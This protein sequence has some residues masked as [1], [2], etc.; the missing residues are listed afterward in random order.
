MTEAGLEVLL[1]RGAWRLRAER[2][3]WAGL[4]AFG[5]GVV[6]A[7]VLI[8][9][10][11]LFPVGPGAMP[12][13]GTV[14]VQ[15]ALVLPLLM[16]A[17]TLALVYARPNPLL[18]TVALRMDVRAGTAEHLVTWYQLRVAAPFPLPLREGVGGGDRL[19]EAAGGGDLELQ[20]G[21]RQAQA[22]ATLALAARFDPKRLLPIRLPEWSRAL[23]LAL[24][25]LCCALLMPPRA[26]TARGL[27]ANELSGLAGLRDGGGLNGAA[28]GD[29]HA[30]HVQV[31][32]PTELL[33]FQLKA[34]DPLLPAA[35]KAEA[36]KELLKKIGSV[37]ESEL[38]PEVRELLNS[39]RS[40]VAIKNGADKTGTQEGAQESAG[41]NEPN[42]GTAGSVAGAAQI[43]DFT[44]RAMATV[45]QNFGD[46]R[47]QLQR[48][49]REIRNTKSEIR[50]KQQ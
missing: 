5:A 13:V 26:R 41:R 28:S 12:G 19:R 46:V 50:R 14:L 30:P 7:S 45:E 36:L 20:R 17:A 32:N 21:F 34:T 10:L 42:E 47:E 2:A 11:R 24:L 33:A 15:G 48:Y 35:A 39:L 6:L 3:L 29:S 44:E 22:A 23:W 37:P 16:A 27:A 43:P 49:Y 4:A 25:L 38:S 31:L 9:V 18:E 8:F 40:E 1:L